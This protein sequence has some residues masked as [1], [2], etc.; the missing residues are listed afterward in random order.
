MI[1]I[2]NLSIGKPE[3]EHTQRKTLVTRNTLK[4]PLVRFQ[5]TLNAVKICVRA[6]NE[7]GLI[8]SAHRNPW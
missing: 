1:R 5:P 6:W 8:V 7:H 2:S 3:T 4:A